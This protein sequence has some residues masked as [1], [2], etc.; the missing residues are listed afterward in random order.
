MVFESWDELRMLRV[1]VYRSRWSLGLVLGLAGPETQF[2]G[3]PRLCRG[4]SS[5]AGSY[6]DIFMFPAVGK[7]D[8]PRGRTLCG[9]SSTSFPFS[10]L[11]S[12]A[13]TATSHNQS[14]AV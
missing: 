4:L 12:P 10:W 3:C 7:G 1:A 11:R 13:S 9:S 8:S 6:Q 5:E 2:H 14:M